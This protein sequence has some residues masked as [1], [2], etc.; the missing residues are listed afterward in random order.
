MYR[1]PENQCTR[2]LLTRST[3]RAQTTTECQHN[4]IAEWFLQCKLVTQL[5]SESTRYFFDNPVNPDF[6][7]LNP[8]GDPDCHQNLITWSLGHAL[9]LQQIS[10]KSVHNFFSYPTESRFRT[11]NSWIRTVIWIVTKIYPIYPLG[12]W[13]MPYSKNFCQN[14]FTTF[15]VI[16]RTDKQ[17]E[18]NT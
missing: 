17:T 16:R 6:G 13:A 14:L 5:W 7:L 1:R 2:I 10:S 8:D 12:P 11:S 15:S 9:L 4:R 18:P 3:Q